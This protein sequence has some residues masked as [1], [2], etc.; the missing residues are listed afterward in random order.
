MEDSLAVES[1]RLAIELHRVLSEI[2][3]V[4][5]RAGAADA[6]RT[7]LDDIQAKLA[8]LT[9]R[10]WPERGAAL[11]ARLA[12]VRGALAA[13]LPEATASGRA[14]WMTFRRSLVPAYESL[15][16][17]LSEY[18]IHVPS[19]R[20]TNHR[21]A[22]FHCASGAL[23]ITILWLVPDPAWT[24]AIAGPLALGAWTLEALRR[25]RPRMNGALMRFF[26]PLAHPHEH[27]RVNSGTWYLSALALL[28]LT[29]APLPCAVGLTALA[30]GDPIAG[31]IGRRYGRVRL[32]HGRSLEGTLAFALA[33]TLASIPV[34]L[35]FAPALPWTSALIIGAS[36]ASAG[37]LAELLS[38]R[39]DDNLSI[40]LAASAAAALVALALGAP[41]G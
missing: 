37:A 25:S 8:G 4:R 24:I 36:G 16:A 7:K 6:V 13:G 15:Q 31:W 18:A 27:R 1:G 5:W 19:L 11:C 34:A 20:P 14:R 40:G 10:R 26:A 21:R 9:G 32:V 23:A 3:P 33:A 22:L 39:V 17:T 30:V 35:A 28:S 41:L 12:D 38:L 29:R 2:D